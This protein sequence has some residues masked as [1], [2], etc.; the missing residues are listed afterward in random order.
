MLNITMSAKKK[1]SVIS[2]SHSM[3]TCKA[4][5]SQ[6]TRIWAMR[7]PLNFIL[8]QTFLKKQSL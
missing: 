8:P 1:I 4:L 2:A 6:L 3:R 7:A 5:E